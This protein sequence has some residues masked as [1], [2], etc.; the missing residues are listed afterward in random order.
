M[1][2]KISRIFAFLKRYIKHPLYII[3]YA[4]TYFLKGFASKI[5][6]Y[7]DEEMIDF[8]KKGKSIIRL[9]DG[10]IVHIQLGIDNPCQHPDKRLRDMYTTIIINYKKNSSYILS[11]PI[12]LNKTN[13]ELRSLG[14]RKLEW[15]LPMKVMFFLC[16][17]KN[18]PYMDAHNF[19]YDNYF[20][21]TVA[22]IFKNRKAIFVTNK[23]TIGKQKNNKNLPWQDAIYI[24]SPGSNAMDKYEDI[25]RALD[26]VLTGFDKNSVVV[27]YAM[28]PVGK[29][30][31]YEYANRGYQG[32]DI[33]KVSEVMFTGESIQHHI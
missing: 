29:Y 6:F 18:I 10:D 5:Q 24:E 20:E 11:V 13:S 17:N 14:K 7:T 25:K 12:F 31:A 27:F 15:G 23:T 33:G 9:G 2:K 3:V 19:Y 1:T 8:L 28:G 22:P 26:K 4:C 16:F 30:L 32:I 21:Q